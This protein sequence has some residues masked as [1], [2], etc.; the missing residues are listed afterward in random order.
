MQAM[1]LLIIDGVSPQSPPGGSGV[2][3]S[4]QMAVVTDLSQITQGDSMANGEIDPSSLGDQYGQVTYS[5]T[6][7]SNGTALV[8]DIVN[9]PTNVIVVGVDL[10]TGQSVGGPTGLGYTEPDN[11]GQIWV[12]Y[13]TSQ[14]QGRGSYVYDASGHKIPDPSSIILAHELG[15]AHDYITGEINSSTPDSVA[16]E[17]ATIVENL[18]RPEIAAYMAAQ[19]SISVDLGQR[20]PT[21]PGGGCNTVASGPDIF[22]GKCFIVTAAFESPLAPEVR[23]LRQL[24]DRRIRQTELGD[25]FFACLHKEY[26]SYSPRIAAELRRSRVFRETAR[27]YLIEPFII[28]LKLAEHVFRAE[29]HEESTF[30]EIGNRLIDAM[31]PRGHLIAPTIL[32]CCNEAG[33]RVRAERSTADGSSPAGDVPDQIS[34]LFEMMAANARELTFSRWAL[35]T[36]LA[37]QARMMLAIE[38]GIGPIPLGEDF[39]A[40]VIEWLKLLPPPRASDE[41]SGEIATDLALF[42]QQFFRVPP[43]LEGVTSTGPE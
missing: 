8:S 43:H 42:R 30:G 40:A 26:Y 12:Y 32:E 15:H 24:R 11:N 29:T 7:S 31:P 19:Y 36:P 37:I 34:Y 5:P 3:S 35:L 33:K 18:I 23:Y 27:T 2:I 14:C 13:D 20:D 22:S 38:A 10:V 16:E 41:S 17:K 21:N 28:F 1:T 4:D 9:G 39:T 25:A 6:L